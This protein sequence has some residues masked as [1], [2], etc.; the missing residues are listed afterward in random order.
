MKLN[1]LYKK[2]LVTLLIIALSTVAVQSEVLSKSSSTSKTYAMST[3]KWYHGSI[4]N[5]F[6]YMPLKQ[7]SVLS[8][9]ILDYNSVIKHYK[10]SGIN[11]DGIYGLGFSD[12]KRVVYAL[13]NNNK[14]IKKFNVYKDFIIE[15]KGATKLKTTGGNNVFNVISTT[16]MPQIITETGSLSFS[17][18]S[19]H[20][21]KD[22]VLY[23]DAILTTP[24]LYCAYIAADKADFRNCVKSADP[25]IPI[26]EWSN[27]PG[28]NIISIRGKDKSTLDKC[29]IVMRNLTNISV[30]KNSM[31][32]VYRNYNIS[33]P[34]NFTK[35]IMDIYNKT[36]Y[37]SQQYYTP[38]NYKLTRKTNV[39]IL[40]IGLP[41][42]RTNSYVDDKEIT[43]NLLPS[44]FNS[45]GSFNYSTLAHELAHVFEIDSNKKNNTF[46]E[47]PAFQEGYA[48]VLSEDVCKALGIDNQVLTRMKD[49]SLTE[50]QLNSFEN[51][52]LNVRD[53]DTN[54]HYKTGYW[55]IRYL[56]ET[57]GKDII[58]KIKNN[59]ANGQV[60]QKEDET[61]EDAHKVFYSS[62]IKK[63]CSKDVF[64][65]FKKWYTKNKSKFVSR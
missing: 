57:Y 35:K 64:S 36:Q 26:D 23:Y 2:I 49:F 40:D 4:I 1:A 20:K 5:E 16:N 51:Y 43:I 47:V 54:M 29:S 22:D 61:F 45:N 65:N 11:M 28:Y 25:R 53:D 44:I 58:K 13:D 56:Q 24:Y 63:A 30:L 12:V 31:V 10:D 9:F 42:A 21:D 18:F 34:E 17:T 62:C 3:E 7:S 8:E 59:I 41:D 6:T 38:T 50:E 37:I 52:F 27:N 19:F 32:N 60:Q 48:E 46:I 55:F 15:C 14:V 33:L 39:K